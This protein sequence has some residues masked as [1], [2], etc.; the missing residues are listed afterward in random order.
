MMN[1]MIRILAVVI[2]VCLDS[3][4]AQVLTCPQADIDDP[5]QGMVK[6]LNFASTNVKNKFIPHSSNI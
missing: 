6:E 4:L 3:A 5:K 2:L 1:Y